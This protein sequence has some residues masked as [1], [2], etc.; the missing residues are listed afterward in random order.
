MS[1]G[2]FKNNRWTAACIIEANKNNNSRIYAVCDTHGN[3]TDQSPYRSELG[4]IYMMMLVI[5]G[6]IRY[7]GITQGSIELGLDG[8]KVMEQA[9]GTFILYPK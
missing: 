4:G 8:K 6:V 2:S 3:S 9:S 1:D 7:H 5:Q